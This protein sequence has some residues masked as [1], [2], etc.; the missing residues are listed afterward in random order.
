M[1][2]CTKYNYM[3]GGLHYK[4]DTCVTTTHLKKYNLDSD[5]KTSQVLCSNISSLFTIPSPPVQR[6]HTHTCLN[7]YGTCSI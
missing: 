5:R 4:A 2:K 3:L 6:K 7:A 1:Y